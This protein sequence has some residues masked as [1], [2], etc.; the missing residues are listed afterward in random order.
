MD[1]GAAL[2]RFERVEAAGE[3]TPIERAIASEVPIAIEFNGIGYAV[4]MATPADLVDLA[5]GFALAERL[6]DAAGDVLDAEAH[7]A[8]G[9][10]LLRVT[11]AQGRADR[12]VERVRHRVSE[13]SCGLCG[14]ENL[15]QAL[16]PIP[17]VSAVWRG[18]DAAVFRAFA[19][20]EAHQPLNRET[21]AV[22]GAAACSADG[23]L[24]LVREDVGRHNAFDKLVGAMLRAGK[25][26][27]GGFALLTSRCSYELVEKAVLSTCPM[28]ATISAPTTLAVQR[29]ADAGLPLRVLV[30]GD[31]LLAPVR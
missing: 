24:R 22:H 30:R 19:A 2:L 29:A 21:R 13:S 12:V 25:G 11:L 8:E 7:P 20:L 9:G 4:L 17:Q 18:D 10:I 26:W 27:E 3:A 1:A 15:E 16:R 14:I 23:G 6:I 31:A 28:L 5:H